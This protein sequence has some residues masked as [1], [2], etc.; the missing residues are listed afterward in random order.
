MKKIIHPVY[1]IYSQKQNVL[2]KSFLFTLFFLSTI[3]ANAEV[4]TFTGTASQVW[5]N[6]L[7]WAPLG[8]PD[9]DDDVRID[10]IGFQDVIINGSTTVKSV[11]IVNG[12]L[13]I[14]TSVLNPT[15]TLTVSGTVAGSPGVMVEANTQLSLTADG[16]LTIV[17]VAGGGL[18][19]NGTISNFGTINI[20]NVGGH[21][22]QNEG[23][24]TNEVN[25]VLNIQDADLR[26]ILNGGAAVIF[27]NQGIINID[28]TTGEGI[29]NG[30]IFSNSATINIGANT[31]VD[32]DGI[33]NEAT[34]TNEITGVLNILDVGQ[35]GILNGS[36]AVIFDNQGLIE[37]ENCPNSEGIYNAMPFIN[38]GSILLGQNGTIGNEAIENLQDFTNQGC[39]T[40]F[41]VFSDNIVFNNGGTFDNEGT[42]IDNASG[43]SNISD[44]TGII[45]NLNGGTFSIVSGN[46]PITTSGH[47]WTGCTDFDWGDPD[48][49]NKN[50]VPL[51]TDNVTIPITTNVPI[52]GI[53]TMAV[54]KSIVIA[55]GGLLVIQ[56]GGNLD[57]NGANTD[58]IFNSGS[59]IN[60]GTI[61]LGANSPIGADGIQNEGTFTNETIGVVDIQSVGRRG[62]LN[63]GLATLFEN[64]GTIEIDD[65]GQSG[66]GG[67]GIFVGSPFINS[68]SL[69]FGQNGTIG[70]EAIRNTDNFTNQSC[71]ALIQIF[72]DNIITDAGTFSN[73]GLII[74]N[75][76]GTSNISNNPGLIQNLNGG[77]FSVNSGNTPFTNAITGFL[78]TGCID[79]DW[80]NP[81][82]WYTNTVPSTTDEVLIP[83]SSNEP[84]IGNSTTA[85]AK[86]III[87]TEAILTIQSGGVLGINGATAEGIFNYGTLINSGLLHIGLTSPIG[88]DGIQNEGTF[89]NETTGTLDI[90]N[91]GQRGILNGGSATLFE[92]KGEIIIDDTGQSGTS[93]D[94]IFVGAPFTNTGEIK[95]GQNG[96]NID[97]VGIFN[98]GATAIFTNDNGIIEIDNVTLDG[99][100]NVVGGHFINQNAGQILIG[101]NGG[102]IGRGGILNGNSATIFTNDNAI[103]EI[104][105][106]TEDGIQ[107][108]ASGHFINQNAGQILIGQN[109][110]NIDRIGIFNLDAGTM[111]TNDNATIEIDNIVEDGIHNVTGSHFTNQNSGQIKIGQNGGNIEHNGILT[112]N[113]TTIFTNDNAIIEIDNVTQEGIQNVAGG[114][115]INENAGQIKIGQNGGNIGRI[116]IVSSGASSIFTNDN[117]TIEINNVTEEGIQNQTGSH[118]TN[119]NA[120]QIK[121]GQNGGNIGNVG[122]VGLDV[123][124]IFTNDN[125]TIEI[126]NV[127]FD[128][129]VNSLGSH[130]T[131]QNAGQIKIGQNGGN[132]GR[133]GILG[134]DIGSL[135][136]NDNATIEIDNVNLDGI[137]NDEGAHFMNQNA[138]Q[139]RIGQYDGNIGRHGIL[140]LDIDAI[141]T[142]D[143]ATVEIDNVAENGIQ[144]VA[145]SN[146]TNQNA[147]QILIGQNSGNIGV[148]GILNGNATTTF[149]N[150]NAIIEIDNVTQDGIQIGDS[151]HFINENSGQILIGQNGGNIERIGILGFEEAI[152]TNT[153]AIIEIDN[154]N[155]DGIQSSASGHFTNENAGQIR[156]GQNDGNIERNGIFNGTNTVFTNDNA[157]IEIDNVV[158]DGI[159]N[160]TGSHFMN[161][162][163]GQILIG[164][165]GGN[166]GRN[167][168]FRVGANAIFTNDNATIEINNVVNDGIQNG[169]GSHFMNE[170]SGQILIGQNGGGIGRNGIFNAG[171][172]VVFTNANATLEIDNV[173]SNSI[174]NLATFNN[175]GCTSL[176][177]VFSQGIFNNNIFNNEGTIIE[178][179]VGNSFISNNT[180]VIQNLNGGNFTVDTGNEPITLEGH[181]W[182]GCADS[183][184]N[185]TDNWLFNIVP[186]LAE[187]VVILDMENNPIVGESTAAIAKSVN[188]GTG[189]ELTI[190]IGGSLA[191]DGAINEAMFNNGTVTNSGTISIGINSPIGLDGIQ[192]ENTFTNESTGILDIQ[193]TGQ[194]G[195]LN[196]SSATLFENKGLIEIDETGQSGS[197]GEG[198]FVASP[199]T[200][201]GQIRIGQNG[202][203]IVGNGIFNDNAVMTIPA[204][205][206]LAIDG[207]VSKAIFNNGTV[208]NLGTISIGVNSPIGSHGIQN[209][210]TF[211][212]ELSGILDIQNVGE[213][214]I[215]NGGSAT[216]FENKG[217]IEIDDTGQSAAVGDGIFVGAPFTNTGQIHIGQNGGNIGRYGIISSGVNANFTN[218]NA[219]IEIDDVALNSIHNLAPF[220]NLGCKSLIHVF[221][222]GIF[223]NNIFSNEGTIIEESTGNSLI[224]NNTGIIQNL[225]GG[226][227]TVETG[228]EPITLEGH[229][230]TGCADSDWNNTD[231]WLFNLVPTVA[232]NVVILEMENNPI[233]GGSTA[234][235]AKSVNIGLGVEL[236][237]RTGGSLVID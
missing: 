64:K 161:E 139:I 152:F 157:T 13:T 62:I 35:R 113:P 126:D 48:N 203:N 156:I 185:N 96:G 34:F 23:T 129:I 220:N 84:I 133:V 12:S 78:W 97:N 213:R 70:N 180:G 4:K 178:E 223:N 229:L 85:F 25:G 181:L 99:I 137:Y 56:G 197:A 188:I 164:Q 141:F 202:G 119:E 75:A 194:R 52:I 67:E 43:T 16:N 160:G 143:N 117:A 201:I 65:T 71:A 112:G 165:N 30:N 196:G 173:N 68:G 47:I 63:G 128:G 28:Q 82:N 147:G 79:A 168:I 169:T 49:W 1:P 162:N 131:N 200:N 92:N 204:G 171:A 6:A 191:I 166:I 21:S 89:R 184:W 127:A 159:Q 44:N 86:S 88:L 125:A 42:I 54:A 57:I 40:L 218:N 37:I 36:A 132:I 225:N 235:I 7:N 154:T 59:L 5:S 183:D 77:T 219:T 174:R 51:T 177:H 231:N 120:G 41:H 90:Q 38:T 66:T 149:I 228:N 227:F 134:R 69:L 118:F 29:F 14:T 115:F 189:A 109:G 153:N 150:D 26:G 148:N 124:A 61:T 138:G 208:T 158:D 151:S 58:G 50:A 140:G 192:N 107:N 32:D 142:N 214:G 217:L 146:I 3:N 195:I 198:F 176:I 11:T 136:T 144:N 226:S 179:S 182:T 122:I 215:L 206:S 60:S 237:I 199:F 72:S 210:G 80:S 163:S 172:N 232:E 116:G 155:L 121:I 211:T 55:T 187:N 216:F 234:A 105:N 135:F 73:E 39:T 91:V 10:P 87:V 104:D 46:A 19:N 2:L 236:I 31:A 98:S 93:R 170:N 209:E 24:F 22:V 190:Q 53:S 186:T 94:G 123:D 114:H 74:E 110:G 101:Q 108:G 76:T 103:I 145:G 167:G 20:T 102:N 81:N 111:F 15:V 224:S 205:G 130:F 8:L 9:A 222:Q 95:I 17:G 100:Q 33:Q 27:D 175:Q 18:F 45:Q 207:T 233:I 230:W 212:N 193:N 106:V 83:D 221:S